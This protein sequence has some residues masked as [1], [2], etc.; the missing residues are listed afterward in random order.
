VN[1]HLDKYEAERALDAPV[2][3]PE[4]AT[5]R[6]YLVKLLST[7]WTETEGFSGKRPLGDSDWQ[8]PVY[9]ALVNGGFL[10][11]AWN[12]E[13]D[14]LED[15]DEA[16]ADKYIGG[17]IE[18]LAHPI[19]L[20]EPPRDIKVARV[21]DDGGEPYFVTTEEYPPT[22]IPA[23]TRVHQTEDGYWRPTKDA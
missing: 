5:V 21:Q 3:H 2:D 9:L 15:F 16:K 14:S 22:T 19:R 8:H 23:G 18:C 10:E 17:L 12:Y 20:V 13:Y 11:G 4:G 7:L 6:E 1:T